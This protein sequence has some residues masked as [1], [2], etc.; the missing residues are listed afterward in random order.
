[1]DDENMDQQD[2]ADLLNRYEVKKLIGSGE[3]CDVFKAIDQWSINN[4]SS[5]I[6]ALKRLKLRQMMDPKNRFDCL[7]EIRLLRKLDHPNIIRHIESFFANNE[8]FIVLEYADAGDLSK[9]LDYFRRKGIM[10]NH[11]NVWNFFTQICTGLSYMH[12]KRVMHRDLKPANV[13]INRDGTV[14]LGDLGLSAILSATSD[15]ARSLV[16]TPYYMAPERLKEME[17][18][19]TADIWSLGCLLYEL[20]T[21]YP[22]FYEPNQNIHGLMRK[23]QALDFVPINVQ[24]RSGLIE[25]AY[26]INSCLVLEPSN[27]IDLDRIHAISKQMNDRYQLNPIGMEQDQ[28]TYRTRTE[29][30]ATIVDDESFVSFQSE[31][32]QQPQQHQQQSQ[33]TTSSGQPKKLKQLYRNLKNIF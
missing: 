22:P 25:I 6:V 4:Q 5:T 11:K 17:Y 12:S 7:R 10:L 30:N 16:G 9:M 27:R 21:L 20:V 1:M 31:T 3:F 26:L 28:S 8:L 14:K 13:L 2:R 32:Q 23:I 15:N 33:P 29:S 18:N 24:N 19:F